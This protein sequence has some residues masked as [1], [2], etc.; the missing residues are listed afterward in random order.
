MTPHPWPWE[1]CGETF[2]GWSPHGAVS[3][4]DFSIAR[5]CNLPKGHR[6]C[7]EWW[8]IMSAG[9]YPLRENR[10]QKRQR[11]VAEK[12]RLAS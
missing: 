1:D 4:M 9:F 8:P 2:Y 5:S 7:C 12:K 10:W 3:G 6:G 11:L